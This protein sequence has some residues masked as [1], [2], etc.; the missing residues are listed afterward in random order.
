MALLCCESLG[1]EGTEF[2]EDTFKTGSA[3]G[4]V[5]TR[6][7]YPK[8]APKRSSALPIKSSVRDVL[9][10]IQSRHNQTP[11]KEPLPNPNTPAHVS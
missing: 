6:K 8:R 1:L 9:K 2:A 4:T 3:E 10:S 5:L 7:R 11:E